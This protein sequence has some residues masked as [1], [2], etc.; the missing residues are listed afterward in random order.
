LSVSNQDIIDHILGRVALN[1]EQK[2][3]ADMNRDG[4]INVCDVVSFRIKNP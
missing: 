2:K 3:E 4:V 1:D